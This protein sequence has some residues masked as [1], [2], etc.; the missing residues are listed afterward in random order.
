MTALRK[1]DRLKWDGA[2]SYDIWVTRVAKD[3][4]WADIFV[5]DNGT[6]ASWSK[7]QPLPLHESF[8]VAS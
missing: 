2:A 1:G 4:T 6:R 7:R 8:T 5:Y 3:Q